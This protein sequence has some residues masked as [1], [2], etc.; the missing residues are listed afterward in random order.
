MF[1]RQEQ[2]AAL[3]GTTSNFV[4]H[5]VSKS[6]ESF[7]LHSMGVWLVELAVARTYLVSTQTIWVTSHYTFEKRSKFQIMRS[8]EAKPKAIRQEGVCS[9]V[10][11][12]RQTSR[13]R[14]GN[15]VET[16]PAASQDNNTRNP[17]ISGHLLRFI[18]FNP[19]GG[20]K[21]IGRRSPRLI[22]SNAPD[23][24]VPQ[25][26][27]VSIA[28]IHLVIQSPQLYPKFSVVSLY[29]TSKS[30]AKVQTD[31][32]VLEWVRK[33]SN[34]LSGPASRSGIRVD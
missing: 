32:V 6:T 16:L 12:P 28:H 15:I 34:Q 14:C 18:N 25:Y 22:T 4:R 5:S 7:I 10:P 23:L 27:H 29:T 8:D 26:S 11:V 30:L 1:Q 9:K 21:G 31:I 2:R 3:D 13:I 20:T 24:W 19:P 17:T 33:G